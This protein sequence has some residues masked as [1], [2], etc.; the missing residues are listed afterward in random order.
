MSETA[1][2]GGFVVAS[3]VGSGVA[4]DSASQ[5]VTYAANPSG[6]SAV[7]LLSCDVVN[8][9]LTRQKLNV[10]KEE[11]QINTKVTIVTKGT[12]TTNRIYPGVTPAAHATAYLA[13]SG[14]VHTA[15]IVGSNIV[16]GKFDTIKDEEG[17]ATI[18][19]NLP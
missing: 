17:F 3:S 14:L 10:H 18:S 5:V 8:I 4:L 16:L 7:G 13:P 1:E 9:D 2:R 6:K 12:V 15:D 11:V 19:F